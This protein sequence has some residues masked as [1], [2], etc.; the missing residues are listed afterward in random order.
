MSRR[1]DAKYSTIR[2]TS[3]VSHHVSYRNK[4][5]MEGVCNTV[6]AELKWRWAFAMTII[7]KN[8]VCVK[9]ER[10]CDCNDYFPKRILIATANKLLQYFSFPRIYFFY[11]VV[12]ISRVRYPFIYEDERPES[13]YSFRIICFILYYW[14]HVIKECM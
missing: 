13:D 11:K 1:F 2:T 12:Y 8:R 9:W 3:V 4:N 10:W 7:I 5:E 6:S 14:E